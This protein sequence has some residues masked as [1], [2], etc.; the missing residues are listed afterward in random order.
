MPALWSSLELAPSFPLVLGRAL[1][2]WGLQRPAGH[3]L[4]KLFPHPSLSPCW[5]LLGQFWC[6]EARL[7]GCS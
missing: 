4:E 7:G 2:P 5:F 3:W 6:G 1:P